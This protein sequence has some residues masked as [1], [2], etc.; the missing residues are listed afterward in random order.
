MIN[1]DKVVIRC[2][3]KLISEDELRG[4][5]VRRGM[6][7][8]DCKVISAM[9]SDIYEAEG[10]LID[11][12]F[13]GTDTRLD[14]KQYRDVD[15]AY[16]DED[17]VVVWDEDNAYVYDKSVI[18]E[19]INEYV[20]PIREG[21]ISVNRGLM[22]MGPPGTGKSVLINLIA[23]MTGFNAVRIDPTEIYS[24]WL[25]ETEQNLKRKLDEA[26]KSE[27]S[28][29]IIDDLEWLALS[30]DFAGSSIVTG[31]WRYSMFNVLASF[32]D[33]INREGDQV[34]VVGATNVNKNMLDPALVREGRF[35]QPKLIPPPGI[36]HVMAWFNVMRQ[37][38]RWVRELLDLLHDSG[39]SKDPEGDVE[40]WLRRMVLAGA[41]MSDIT[42][43]LRGMYLKLKFV[44]KVKADELFITKVSHG[45]GFRRAYP[46]SSTVR[47]SHEAETLLNGLAAVLRDV[48][49]VNG[50][51]YLRY[52]I[53]SSDVYAKQIAESPVASALTEALVSLSAARLG[54]ST[55]A[56]ADPKNLENALT[57]A[58]LMRSVVIIDTAEYILEYSLPTVLNSQVPVILTYPDPKSI[59]HFIPI[60]VGIH[61]IH[62]DDPQQSTTIAIKGI[63]SII[64]YYYNVPMCEEAYRQLLAREVKDVG[65]YVPKLIQ[66]AHL[67]KNR[68]IQDCAS[69]LDEIQRG[70]RLVSRQGPY[71]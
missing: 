24:K 61:L 67:A 52:E 32:F 35:G 71:Y 68:R 5:F 69:A 20:N 66:L 54:K 7:V 1:C 55:I 44:G 53:D 11:V 28:L 56:I 45:L 39:I 8:G 25:G 3:G 15:V 51:A 48:I 13:I 38:A 9:K 59:A 40:D 17:V 29:L 16:R 21:G 60:E 10:D 46:R 64:G 23:K 36:K 70:W 43:G 62:A 49:G 30:R 41:P 65:Y 57:M 26:I 42:T 33:K 34:I 14:I 27:P 63:L 2:E 50:K 58:E 18:D 12:C 4:R 37:R 22:L 19:I 31:E 47:L 6:R